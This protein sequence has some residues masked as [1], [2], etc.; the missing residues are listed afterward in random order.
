MKRTWQS[1]DDPPVPNRSMGNSG[2]DMFGSFYTTAGNI[3]GEAGVPME[4]N[5]EVQRS[6]SF[7]YKDEQH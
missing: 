3:I 6:V 4:L 5:A 2:W 1:A 7:Y